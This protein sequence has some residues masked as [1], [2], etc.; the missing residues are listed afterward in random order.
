MS[1]LT[2]FTGTGAFKGAEER[3]ELH[4]WPAWPQYGKGKFE[5]LDAYRASFTGE[6]DIPRLYRGPVNV[7]FDL[8]D[9]DPKAA[10]SPC[11]VTVNGHTDHE[12]RY[13]VKGTKLVFKARFKG[14]PRTL[15][16][17]RTGKEQNCTML[18]VK[19]LQRQDLAFASDQPR[20]RDSR[21]GREVAPAHGS[22]APFRSTTF[23]AVCR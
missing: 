12:A 11:K 1:K 2:Q 6:V 21:V 8:V 17:Y 3:I 10:A 13:Q 23:A 19:G 15:V 14:K 16:I 5:E 4:E 20:A 9:R 22:P 18:E 7:S